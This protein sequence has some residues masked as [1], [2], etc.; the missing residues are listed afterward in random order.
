MWTSCRIERK[1]TMLIKGLLT[2]LKAVKPAMCQDSARYGMYGVLL[3]LDKKE[4]V[5]T[6]GH[7]MALVGDL[8]VTDGTGKVFIPADEV[9]A[10]LSIKKYPVDEVEITDAAYI[11]PGLSLTRRTTKE[12]FPPYEQVMV[13]E[14]AATPLARFGGD[15]GY[16]ANVAKAFKVY[17]K[18]DSDGPIVHLTGELAPILFSCPNCPLKYIIMRFR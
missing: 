2:A 13:K 9:D 14:A 16:L 3:N 5:A 6:D 7:Q 4:L 8:D 18:K 15:L 1:R 11:V 10:L 12:H 17:G